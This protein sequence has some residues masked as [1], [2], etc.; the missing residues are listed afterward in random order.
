MNERALAKL[1]PKD[2]EIARKVIQES[3]T[4]HAKDPEGAVQEV[5]EAMM[6]LDQLE[7]RVNQLRAEQ[8]QIH[9]TSADV[10]HTRRLLD[11]ANQ[12]QDQAENS[13]TF[14]DKLA[15]VVEAKPII[16]VPS[17]N[18]KQT[19]PK[20]PIAEVVE[21]KLA[22]RVTR[23]EAT[24][25][26]GFGIFSLLVATGIVGFA[27]T[28]SIKSSNFQT[29]YEE[30][31]RTLSTEQRKEFERQNLL[32]EDFSPF[33]STHWEIRYAPDDPSFSYEEPTSSNSDRNQRLQR[34]STIYVPPS[35]LLARRM[36]TNI[37][38]S[39]FTRSDT[40]EVIR[41]DLTLQ[42]ISPMSEENIV[43]RLLNH[44]QDA[45]AVQD[46]I[47]LYHPDEKKPMDD[48][49]YYMRITQPNSNREF[50]DVRFLERIPTK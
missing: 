40:L 18:T 25:N 29:R 31:L 14:L 45:N 17:S 3:M 19:K 23:R 24:E 47:H 41:L 4:L 1:T 35:W 37:A 21:G 12:D 46:V 38:V 48:L 43:T 36:D 16:A 9:V 8:A 27:V 5:G 39:S 50:Y 34:G 15:Q 44:R 30:K 42:G 11:L 32:T 10:V 2:F 7:R 13:G 28:E 49:N 22:K 6:K 20:D 26:V 33:T